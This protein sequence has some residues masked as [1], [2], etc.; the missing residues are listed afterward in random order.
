MQ[1]F[2]P[3]D[4]S[5]PSDMEVSFFVMVVL[6][7]AELLRK[8]RSIKLDGTPGSCGTGPSNLRVMG[9]RLTGT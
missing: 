7:F 4:P 1:I 5:V 9:D 2:G 6:D 3:F 8:N